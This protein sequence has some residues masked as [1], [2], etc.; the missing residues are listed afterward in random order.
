MSDEQFHE[1]HGHTVAAWTAVAIIILGS[2]ISAV[3]FVIAM[4]WVVVAGAV[5]MLIG[6]ITGKVMQ[7]MGFGAQADAHTEPVA[8][9]ADET[10]A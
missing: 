6:A 1:D 9:L 8:V 3:G 4:P 7:M 10:P 5:V 2:V